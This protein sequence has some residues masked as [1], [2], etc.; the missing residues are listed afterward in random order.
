M[1]GSKLSLI[2]ARKE[3][4]YS[5]CF[6]TS[7]T[8]KIPCRILDQDTN[9]SASA[10]NLVVVFNCSLNFRRHIP[11][12]F[13]ACFYFYHIC[14][15]RRIRKKSVLNSYCQSNGSGTGQYQV[16]LLTSLFC[17]MPEKD[18][19]RLQRFQNCLA[20]PTFYLFSSN[21]KTISFLPRFTSK[22]CTKL[23]DP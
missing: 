17:C 9:A 21:S 10:K 8:K 12:T 6:Q 13:G 2:L 19:A 4:L 14:D 11:Q 7:V 3:I 22:I 20:S 23:F 5:H 18:I 1:I 15:M 16:R